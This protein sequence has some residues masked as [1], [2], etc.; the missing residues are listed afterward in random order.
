MEIKPGQRWLF[1]NADK[2]EKYLIKSKFIVE[3]IGKRYGMYK[4]KIIQMFVEDR[5]KNDFVGDFFIENNV[6]TYFHN[7]DKV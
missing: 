6:W 7:Q 2:R 4:A 5:L 3:I 1:D